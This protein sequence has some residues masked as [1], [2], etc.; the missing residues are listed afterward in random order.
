MTSVRH[1]D[2]GDIHLRFVKGLDIPYAVARADMDRRIQEEYPGD[3]LGESG[4]RA[5]VE[6]RLDPCECGG[7]FR[8][9]AP[10]RCSSCRSTSE[11][12]DDDESEPILINFD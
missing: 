9:D 7:R 2:M 8:H 3:P 5:A 10:P 4:Y 11:M 1:Q 12:W 6:S